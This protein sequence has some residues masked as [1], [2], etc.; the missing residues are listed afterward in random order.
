MCKVVILSGISGAGKSTYIQ[1][2]SLTPGSFVIVSADHYFLNK[3]GFYDFDPTKLAFA[4]GAC[5]R[6]FIESM[7]NKRELVIVDNTN[8]TSE[9][10]SPYVL[11]AQSYGYEYEIITLMCQTENDVM[12][13]NKR[14]THGVTLE[15]AMAQHKCLT[16]R[17]LMPWWKNTIIPVKLTKIN[18]PDSKDIVR[19]AQMI[20]LIEPQEIKNILLKE[21]YSEY[22]AFLAYKAGEVYARMFVQ[23]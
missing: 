9:E 8:A 13:A 3:D 5:F 11:G 23:A 17:R 15:T 21:G 12:A 1:S 10:V 16:D 22:G 2:M 19:V 7:Q 4:H 18:A 6:A 14:N 20:G